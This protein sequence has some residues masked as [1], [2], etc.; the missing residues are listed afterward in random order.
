MENIAHKAC[1]AVDGIVV[2]GIEY[3]AGFSFEDKIVF[4]Y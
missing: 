1:S 3:G 4:S 2:H